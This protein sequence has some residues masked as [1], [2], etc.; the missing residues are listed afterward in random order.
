M[1]ISQAIFS[2]AVSIERLPTERNQAMTKCTISS[3]K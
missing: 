2:S 1:K 3:Q